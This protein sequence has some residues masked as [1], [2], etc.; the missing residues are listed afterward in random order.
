[1]QTFIIDMG[2]LIENITDTTIIVRVAWVSHAN[3]YSKHVINYITDT[4]VI[5]QVVRVSDA[6]IYSKHGIND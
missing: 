6:N 1:M 5:V 3:I 2:L 4:T